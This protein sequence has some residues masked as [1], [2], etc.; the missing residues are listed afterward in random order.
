MCQVSYQ[1]FLYGTHYVF[2][3]D[4]VPRVGLQLFDA[5]GDL[6]VGRINMQDFRLN[7][8]SPRE[9]LRWMADVPRPRHFRHVNQTLH[10]FLDFNEGTVV[11]HA[12]H[13]AV[14]HRTN[15]IID[16]HAVPRMWLKLL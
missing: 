8:L 7:T 11:G 10:T 16:I 6:P 5:Q 2:R 1:A 9:H 13:F 14:H 4:L 3:F 12:H 15:G